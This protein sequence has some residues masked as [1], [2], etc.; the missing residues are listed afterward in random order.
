MPDFLEQLDRVGEW[1]G[2]VVR[3]PL[4]AAVPWP[5]AALWFVPLVL[6]MPL[7]LSESPR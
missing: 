6:P 7:N 4:L 3:G 1:V 5:A 2:A